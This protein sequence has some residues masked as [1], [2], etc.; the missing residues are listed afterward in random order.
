MGLEAVKEEILG[1]AK[2]QA[3]SLV[4]N[5]RKESDRLM[6]EAEKKAEEMREKNEAETKIIIDRLKRQELASAGLEKKKMVLECKKQII[7]SV[8]AEAKKMLEGLDDKKRESFIK[9]L[10]ESVQNDIEPMHFY[11]NK[12]DI[13]F[14]KGLDAKAADIIGGLIA[15]NKDKTIIVDYSFEAMLESIKENQ[16]QEISKILFE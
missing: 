16:L 6:K 12:R 10:L 5:A 4:A 2:K 15:E 8:F 11:C 9:K 1:N 13:K 14:L 3:N 7:E